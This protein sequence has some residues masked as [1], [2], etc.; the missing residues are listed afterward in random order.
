[1]WKVFPLKNIICWHLLTLDCWRTTCREMSVMETAEERYYWGEIIYT[2]SLVMS[3]SHSDWHSTFLTSGTAGVVWWS[4]GDVLSYIHR[5]NRGYYKIHTILESSGWVLYF[6]NYSIL[7]LFI[8]KLPTNNNNKFINL[9][10]V[11]FHWHP[12]EVTCFILC[13]FTTLLW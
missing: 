9:L 8:E 12:C 1:M 5:K 3:S 13:L 4:G 7:I 6:W 10:P 2:D 11:H